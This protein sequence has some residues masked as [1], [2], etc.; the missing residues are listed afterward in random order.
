MFV[1]YGLNSF[2]QYTVLL[3]KSTDVVETCYS[4]RYH[5]FDKSKTDHRSLSHQS[6]QLYILHY[7]KQ[8]YFYLQSL[9]TVKMKCYVIKKMENQC[10]YTE[11]RSTSSYILYSS[12]KYCQESGIKVKI[13]S[14]IY[15]TKHI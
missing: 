1:Y 14:K 4:R 10:F 15:G 8:L 12:I 7:I 3:C 9:L 6:Q 11:K 5:L 13:F 2:F